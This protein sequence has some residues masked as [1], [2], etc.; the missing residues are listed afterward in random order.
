MKAPELIMDMEAI[1]KKRKLLKV[2][3]QILWNTPV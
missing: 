2:R 3:T 1:A